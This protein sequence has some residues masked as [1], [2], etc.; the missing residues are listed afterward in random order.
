MKVLKSWLEDY[1]EI[2]MTNE[3]LVDSLVASGTE[4]ESASSAIDNGIIVSKI[5]KIENHPNADRLKMVTLYNGTNEV[6]VICGASNIL[7]GQKVALA[8][9]GAKIGQ[10]TLEEADIRG[11]KSIGMICSEKELGLGEDHTGI[12]VLDSNL[13]EGTRVNRIINTDVVYTLEITPNRGDCLS[14]IGIAREVSAIVGTEI[15]KVPI[16]LKMIGQNSSTQISVNI[17]DNKACSQYLARVIKGVKIGPSPD[18]LQKRLGQLG[19]KTINNVVDATNYIMLDLGQPL[20]SFDLDKV[21]DQKIVVRYALEGE[22]LDSLDGE[23]LNLT[24]KML[25]IADSKKPLA[26]AGI[27]GSINS[28]IDSETTS[29]VLEAAVFDKKLIRKTRKSLGISTEASYRFERGIDESG[30]QYAIDK[31]TKLIHEIAGGNIL[32]GI[33]KDGLAP[34]PS[35]LK[36][37]YEKINKL[38]GLKLSDEEINKYLKLYGFKIEGGSAL[39]PSHRHD[40]IVWQD[41]AE[42]VARIYGYDKITDLPLPKTKK[43]VV[44]DYHLKEAL[45]DIL[46]S[47]GLSEVISYTFVSEDDVSDKKDLLEVENPVQPEN[48]YLRPRL[49]PCLFKVIAKNSSFDP[50]AIYELGNVFTKKK[51]KT[52]LAVVLAGSEKVVRPMVKNVVSKLTSVFSSNFKIEVHDVDV[53]KLEKIKIRKPIVLAFEIDITNPSKIVSLNDNKLAALKKEIHYRQV[54]KFPSVTR[55]LAFVVKKDIDNRMIVDSIYKA[56]DWVNRVELFDVYSSDKIGKDKK[57]LAFHIYLQDL[58]KTMTDADADELIDQI[59]KKMKIEHKA[60]LRT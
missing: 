29:V 5:T 36:V 3:E 2:N 39:V 51:E 22:K 56:S 59:I 7:V 23:R 21:K 26:L 34:N 10:T 11:L 30:V 48:K 54:S 52:H 25:V 14:H 45:K 17:E 53:N 41:L 37:E 58:K 27:I 8:Q 19:V 38:L 16:K 50:I 33:V 12:L 6:K 15:K 44:S 35:T 9:P 43:P 1:I 24:E 49:L 4:I 31:A 18:W 28:Q 32:S 13:K 46:T 42:E 55:D 57:S 20:H 60:L 47:L 40:I